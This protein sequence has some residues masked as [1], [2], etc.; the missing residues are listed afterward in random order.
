MSIASED[1]VIDAL[2]IRDT[3][4]HNSTADESKGYIPKTMIIINHLDESVS[5]QLQGS[6]DDT[7]TDPLTV[8]DAFVVPAST[9]DYETLTDYMPWLR[10]VAT[11]STAPTTGTLSAYI[12]KVGD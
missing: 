8:G 4:A 2:A 12:A 7:F 5:C 3:S 9:D 11:C 6:V 10:I 1:K